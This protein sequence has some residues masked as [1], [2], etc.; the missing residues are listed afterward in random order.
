MTQAT[1]DCFLFTALACEAKP[2][3]D[4]YRLRKLP[5]HRAFAIYANETTVVVVAGIGKTAMAAAVGYSMALF[6]SAFPILL[7][8]G[9]AGH[10]H[11]PVG[12]LLL[13]EKIVDG[14]RSQKCY[15]PQLTAG[16]KHPTSTLITVTSPAIAYPEPCLYDM[17][18]AAF[19]ETAVKFSTSEL[20]QCLKIVSDN[21]QQSLEAIK[22]PAV[23]NWIDRHTEAYDQIIFRLRSLRAQLIEQEPDLYETLL[24]TFH[25]SATNRSR[26]KKLLQQW[27]IITANAP[28]TLDEK[29]CVDAKTMLVWLEQQIAAQRYEL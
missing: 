23:Q 6:R 14:E 2:L 15:Y 8:I 11:Q 24:D 17:E 12:Q 29:R 20:I 1:P 19:Y 13:A 7:N 4:H 22:A 5:E 26:L 18:A 3:I 27:E 16:F 28:L 9:I 10:P 25:F 21:A